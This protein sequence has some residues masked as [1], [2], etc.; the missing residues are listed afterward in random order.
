LS[1]KHISIIGGAG[2]VGLPL[3]LAFAEKKFKIHLI[4]NNKKSLEII[5]SN[6]M[7][8][9]EFGA[10]KVLNKSLKNKL[11]YFETD[12]KNLSSSKYIIICIGTPVNSKLKPNLKVFFNL[13]FKLKKYV[14]KNQLIIV[15]SSVYPGTIEKI[16]KILKPKNKNIV[17]CPER[18]VQSKSLI[19]LPKLPQIIACDK[20]KVFIETKKLFKKITEKI[21][22]TSVLEA[23][24][25][26]LYSNAN[27]YINFAIANQLYSICHIHNLN[28]DRIRDIMQDGYARNLN[29]AKAG[30]TSGPCLLKDTM[31]LHSFCNN[32]FE[33]GS[34]AMKINEK[35]PDLIIEKLKKYKNYKKKTIGLL[36]L[37][38]K[39]ETDDTRDSL[40]IKL[41]NKLKKLKLKI[42][43]SD[44]YYKNKKNVSK[45]KL[46]LKSNI[47]IFGAPH[48]AYNNLKISKNKK[49]IDI[50]GIK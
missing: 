20:E 18:I 7:P 21:I 32:N 45:E 26:K 43:Q 30:F 19:E 31:Q 35:I 9:M 41:L 1:K 27:R 23:E 4:D 16:K 37:A 46:I 34:A 17:Y 50:W 24:L 25:I 11:F 13:I 38:F 12:L 3:G 6:K 33:L 44:E 22:K 39:G 8:F 36:G 47:I 28:F 15:R 42:L 29:L 14:K 10:N 40:S 49:I 2:H 48:K 5:K